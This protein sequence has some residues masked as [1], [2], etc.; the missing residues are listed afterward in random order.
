LFNRYK[1]ESVWSVCV[2]AGF[3]YKIMDWFF[4]KIKQKKNIVDKADQMNIQ[5]TMRE[6]VDYY[7]WNV[8]TCGW[9][10]IQKKLDSDKNRKTKCVCVDQRWFIDW[11][12]KYV[13]IQ[14]QRD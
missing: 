14:Y 6:K 8:L 7:H 11:F 1:Q 12:V 13:W 10:K 2:D 5:T 9:I 4:V 3:S